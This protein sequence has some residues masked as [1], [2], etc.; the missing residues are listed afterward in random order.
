MLEPAN[1]TVRKGESATLSCRPPH[2]RPQAQVSWFK[3]K[4]LLHPGLHY[5]ADPNGDLHFH[6]CFG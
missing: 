6:R 1:L 3:N 5:T 2:S 4:K